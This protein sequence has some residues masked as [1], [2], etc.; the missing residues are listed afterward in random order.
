MRGTTSCIEIIL[1]ENQWAN[2][3]E[4]IRF[5]KGFNSLPTVYFDCFWLNF[6]SRCRLIFTISTKNHNSAELWFLL[7]RSHLSSWIFFGTRFFRKIHKSNAC[8]NCLKS[9]HNFLKETAL[10]QPSVSYILSFNFYSNLYPS[11][12]S[13]VHRQAGQK[14]SVKIE[15]WFYA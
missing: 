10:R 9:K 11:D 7:N 12:Q 5:S 6:I 14:F 4:Y 1:K 2:E 13:L 8:D 15:A 3:E